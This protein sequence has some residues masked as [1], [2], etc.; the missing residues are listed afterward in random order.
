MKRQRLAAVL[1]VL[2]LCSHSLFS[3]IQQVKLTSPADMRGAYQMLKQIID[4]GTG[5]FALNTQ[6]MKIFTDKY[7]MYAH[8]R[9]E[10]D[11]MAEFGVGT[12][13]VE[14]GKVYEHM[15]FGPSG[16]G[17]NTFELAI[18]KRNDGYSQ[19]IHFPPDNNGVSVLLTEDYTNAGKKIRSPLDGAWSL[20]KLVVVDKDGKTATYQSDE[21]AKEFK[22]FESGNFMWA[23]W[24]RNKEA[25]NINTAYGYGSFT[26]DNPNQITETNASSTFASMLVGKPVTLQIKLTGKD[27]YEQT[28]AGPDGSKRTEYYE[29]M[30]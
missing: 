6:Q 10:T 24:I 25:N 28:N 21:N 11:S 23:S 19:V 17:N 22:F 8:R 2:F 16:P 4:T 1:F 27:S 18:E 26:L 7:V 3:Q 15:F 12:F 13:T 30:Q 29:R 14:N 20:K 9:S 5:E